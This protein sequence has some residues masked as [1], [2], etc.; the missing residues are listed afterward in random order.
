[1]AALIIGAVAVVLGCDG[2]AVAPAVQQPLRAGCEPV[3]PE[4]YMHV[5]VPAEPC[6]VAVCPAGDECQQ[7]RPH[8]NIVIC[9][10]PAPVDR[11][12]D[13]DPEHGD[14]P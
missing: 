4:A 6:D 11:T 1:M 8:G 13:P 2:D 5:C 9:T 7:Y 12:P 3:C 14:R 10:P